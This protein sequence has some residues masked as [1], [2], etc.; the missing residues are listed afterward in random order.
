MWLKHTQIMSTS[1]QIIHVS[2]V[3][4]SREVCR[5]PWHLQW[6]SLPALPLQQSS[7]TSCTSLVL[8]RQMSPVSH[9]LVWHW[10]TGPFVNR[11]RFGPRISSSTHSKM[12]CSYTRIWNTHRVAYVLFT[13][14]SSRR[15]GWSVQPEF[16]FSSMKQ[17]SSLLWAVL[18]CSW[19]HNYLASMNLNTQVGTW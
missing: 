10:E 8:K 7:R 13:A 5:H 15:T 18:S 3:A 12:P 2:Q 4:H 19:G 17:H 14:H 9:L 11:H 1:Y 16:S 6:L